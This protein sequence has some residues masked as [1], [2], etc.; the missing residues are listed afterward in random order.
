MKT[1]LNIEG[2]S[3]EHCVKHLKETLKEVAGVKRADV[4]LKAKNA[5]V[6]HADSVTLDTLKAAVVEAGFEVV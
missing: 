2:M 5:V 6:D 4:S 1:T 3:C